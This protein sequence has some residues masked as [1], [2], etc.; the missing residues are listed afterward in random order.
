MPVRDGAFHRP[1]LGIQRTTL[2]QALTDA[3]LEWWEDPHNTDERF[4]RVRVRQQV[5]P[6][7]EKELGPG[8]AQA[9]ARTAE[10]FREDSSAL[11][12]QA[13]QWFTEHA[14]SEGEG[15]ASLE[16]A[17]LEQT[18]MALQTR[19]LRMLVVRAGGSAPTYVH[20]QQMLRLLEHWRGQSA[21]D[22]SGASV[23][24]VDGRIVARKSV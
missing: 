19:V 20:T 2:R 5:M 14:H 13:S 6:V 15:H 4:T 24:R 17:D 22:V 23:E 3:G 16:V 21:L 1:F 11:D 9:L 12:E 7:L 10:L 8:V 18:S